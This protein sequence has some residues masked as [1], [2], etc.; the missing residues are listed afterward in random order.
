MSAVEVM[1][2]E[3]GV[4]YSLLDHLEERLE[5]RE[6]GT[7][8]EIL[9]E[10]GH[11]LATALDPHAELEDE[12]LFGPLVAEAGGAAGPVE[13]MMEEHDDIRSLL[14]EAGG[15][16]DEERARDLLLTAVRT[17]REHFEKEERMAA[18]LARRTFDAGR[19][20]EAGAEWLRRRGVR[21]Y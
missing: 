18:P 12:L 10:R 19:L 1:L 9:R 6:E 11:L 20:E 5:D 17:A 21:A 13:R 8:I 15:E 3:H 2:G 14:A 4:L 16:P 7:G